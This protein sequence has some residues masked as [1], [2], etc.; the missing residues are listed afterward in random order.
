MLLQLIKTFSTSRNL[1]QIPSRD[2]CHFEHDPTSMSLSIIIVLGILVSYLP[3]HYRIISSKSSHGISPWFL[4]LGSTSNTGSLV[5]A[6]TLQWGVVRCC[7]VLNPGEC[8]ESL[9]GIIQVF[10]QWACFNV[11]LILSLIYFP[12][13]LKYVR[14][15]PVEIRERSDSPLM[16]RATNYSSQ[17]LSRFFLK[18]NHRTTSSS[19]KQPRNPRESAPDQA[20]TSRSSHDS[21]ASSQS[22]SSE[23]STTFPSASSD[24]SAFDPSNVLPPSATRFTPLTLSKEYTISLVLAFVVFIHFLF[25]ALVTLGLLLL[26]PKASLGEPVRT[27]PSHSAEHPT[28]RLLRIWASSSGILS[29]LLAACQYLPQIQETFQA[30]LVRALSI[31]MMLIQTPGSFLFVYSL[32]IRPGLN[33]T[34]WIVYLVTGI[35]QGVLLILCVL[36]KIRQQANGVDDWGKPLARSTGSAKRTGDGLLGSEGYGEGQEEGPGRSERSPLLSALRPPSTFLSPSSSSTHRP[37]SGKQRQIKDD[38]LDSSH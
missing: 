37:A 14:V 16:D 9:L 38:S 34:T 2:N 4:L 20:V 22:T 7:Q 27:P 5:N 17:F 25:S 13:D 12:R 30:K 35:L 32:A 21:L 10:L 29:L 24:S 28:V 31:P 33:W 1:D 23:H 18:H 26:L 11:I 36:W 15:V 3:Q 8:A 19:S 6:V